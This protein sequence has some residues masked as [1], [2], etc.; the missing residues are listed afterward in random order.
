MVIRHILDSFR[1][2]QF[3][4]HQFDEAKFDVEDWKQSMK[5]GT[6]ITPASW[7]PISQLIL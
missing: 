3:T 5:R 1:A 4:Y 6:M 2:T 7:K